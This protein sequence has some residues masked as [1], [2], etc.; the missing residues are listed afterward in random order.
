VH[1]EQPPWKQLIDHAS[2]MDERV[3]LIAMIFSDGRQ[4]EI[5]EQLSGDEAQ[6]FVDRI[7]EVASF[8]Y[9]SIDSDADLQILSIRR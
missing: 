7:D 1:S 5:V 4:L 6:T 9:G 8:N 3:S 2:A